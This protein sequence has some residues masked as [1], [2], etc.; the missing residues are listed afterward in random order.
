[1][2]VERPRCGNELAHRNSNTILSDDGHRNEF[3]NLSLHPKSSV[4]GHRFVIPSFPQSAASAN[5]ELTRIPDSSARGVVAVGAMGGG[6][7]CCK[8]APIVSGY[9]FWAS[10]LHIVPSALNQSLGSCSCQELPVF[11]LPISSTSSFSWK[12]FTSHSQL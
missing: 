8:Q 7:G 6:R 12:A 3:F 2:R 10:F 11:F 9:W 1:M 5:P 4:H